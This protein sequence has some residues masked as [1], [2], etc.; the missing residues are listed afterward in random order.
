MP[1]DAPRLHACAVVR[2][3]ADRRRRAPHARVTAALRPLPLAADSAAE[4]ACAVARARPALVAV[5]EQTDGHSH[6]DVC[7]AIRA[8]DPLVAI[9]VVRDRSDSVPALDAAVDGHAALDRIDEMAARLDILLELKR[10]NAGAAAVRDRLADDLRAFDISLRLLPDGRLLPPRRA[11]HASLVDVRRLRELED[12]LAGLGAACVAVYAYGQQ[13]TV[14]CSSAGDGL[15]GAWPCARDAMVRG[16]RQDGRA[17]DGRPLAAFPVSLSFRTVRYPLLALCVA[18]PA[19]SPER[20]RDAVLRIQAAVAESLSR[21]ASQRYAIAHSVLVEAV[22]RSEHVRAQRRRTRQLLRANERLREINRLKSEFFG[23]VSHEL[24][25]PMTSIIG[26]ASL[27]LRGSAGPLGDKAEH[28][29]QRVLANAR[30]LH[31]AISDILEF[32]QL[33]TGAGE[34]VVSRFE[35]RPLLDECLERV[36]PTL[37]DKPIEVV[38]ELP[39]DLPA[40][41]TDRERLQQILLH[42]LSNAA[43]FTSRGQVRVAASVRDGEPCGRL[44]VAVADTGVGMPSDAL[45]HIFEEFRQ[46]DG[47]STRSHGGAGLGLSLVKHLCRLLHGELTVASELER[48]STFTLVVPVSLPSA[49]QAREQVRRQ[50]LGDEPNPADRSTPIVLAVTDEPRLVLDLR[51]WLAPCGYRVAAVFDPDE[52]LSRAWAILPCAVLLDVMVPGSEVWELA[53]VLGADPRTAAVP[54]IVVSSLGGPEV[55]QAAGAADWLPRPLGPEP[56][57]NALDRLRSTHAGAILAIV[58]DPSRRDALR[59]I[60]RDAGYQATTCAT[61]TDACH[62][63]SS[64]FDL[65]LLDPEG[66]GVLT[67]LGS[68]RSGFLADTPVVAWLPPGYPERDRERLAAAAALVEQ[69]PDD[70]TELLAAVERILHE[71]HT[72]T[73]APSRADGS[74]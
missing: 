30:S 51:R 47:S 63:S 36:Q 37:G 55:A 18:F 7:R 26:F 52:A 46:V 25:T 45:P 19:A 65:I 61:C 17:P 15:P 34:P 16:L 40:L 27:L 71:R 3:D 62:F 29:V 69:S 4:A 43:K 24:R 13:P 32:A 59:H 9:A 35:L 66:E 39:A 6:L 11:G 42:L 56:L 72:T 20:P 73:G 54:L 2:A 60:L 67:A 12:A 1:N 23:N 38:V 74:S 57:L 48:G 33:S 21:Q 68:V 50:V 22:E 28:F 70:P 44:S 41:E 31:G 49:Q 8:R 14:V 10:Y 5:P 58:G 53:D 64:H